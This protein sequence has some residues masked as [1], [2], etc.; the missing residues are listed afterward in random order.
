MGRGWDG[1]EAVFVG[2]VGHFLV[3]R[4]LGFDWALYVWE[5]RG[6]SGLVKENKILD[7]SVIFCCAA[8][9]TLG[10]NGKFM[11][12]EVYLVQRNY[13]LGMPDSAGLDL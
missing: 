10:L 11:A 4:L 7:L 13:I 5:V 1:G 3:L 12:W 9:V 8:C 6:L 2:W